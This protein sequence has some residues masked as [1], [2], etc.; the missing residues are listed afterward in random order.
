MA[1]KAGHVTAA[2]VVHGAYGS[3]AL[4]LAVALTGVA[5]VMPYIALQLV[6]MSVII[7]ALGVSGEWPLVAAFLV[8]RFTR[9]PPACV[10]RR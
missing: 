7:K 6:G 10:P 8:L 2:D 1:A 3:R 5:A 9:I 4:E